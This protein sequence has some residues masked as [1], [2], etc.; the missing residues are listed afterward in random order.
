MTYI[1]KY[2]RVMVMIPSLLMTLQANVLVSSQNKQVNTE[3]NTSRNDTQSI[4]SMGEKQPTI[5]EIKPPKIEKST[6]DG[7]VQTIQVGNKNITISIP[8]VPKVPTL[9]EYNLSSTEKA[10]ER[11]IKFSKRVPPGYIPHH[12]DT[13]QKEKHANAQKVQETTAIGEIHDGQISA[14]LRGEFMEAAQVKQHLEDAGFQV[15]A[16]STLNKTKDL[17]SVIFTDDTLAKLAN[18][19]KRGF[20]AS[21]R[22]LIDTKEQTISI[23]NPLYMAKGFLQDDFNEKEAKGVLDRIL[24]AFKNLHNAKDALKFQLL[25]NYQF[26]KGMPLYQDMIEVAS[27][28]NLVSKLKNNDNV[29]FIQTLA[30]KNVLIGIKLGD[31][32]SNFTKKIGRNNAALLPYPILIEGDKAY[33]LNPK[34]YISFM[35]PKLSMSGFMTIATVPTAII[36]ECEKIFK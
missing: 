24:T 6:S 5:T 22:V 34:Y 31:S 9:K 15:L 12:F 32:T 28:A 36:E 13:L 26:M 29:L 3:E 17:T 2:L 16:V 25:A 7:K 1:M 30:N 19:P 20:I 4:T 14:Y 23:T 21:L 18:K 8:P 35:Y 27:G 33:I 10:N 11:S